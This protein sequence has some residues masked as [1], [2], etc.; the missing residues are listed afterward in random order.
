MRLQKSFRNTS[1]LLTGMGALYLGLVVAS[2]INDTGSQFTE[3]RWLIASLVMLGTGLFGMM[4][5]QK[6]E[7]MMICFLVGIFNFA[8]FAGNIAIDAMAEVGSVLLV[9]LTCLPLFYVTEARKLKNWTPSQEAE[10][11]YL[12]DR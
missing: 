9:L 7:R 4:S 8:L 5:Y 11:G 2:L 1:V 10:E 12:G 6:R 3:V